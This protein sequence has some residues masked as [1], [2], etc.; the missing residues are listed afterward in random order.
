MAITVELITQDVSIGLQW[1]TLS[2]QESIGQPDTLNIEMVE[3][4]DAIRTLLRPI[5]NY[6]YTAVRKNGALLFSGLATKLLRRNKK[7]AI[8]YT[9]QAVGWEY[10]APKRLV[11]TPYTWSIPPEEEWGDALPTTRH[12]AAS[13]HS[14]PRTGISLRST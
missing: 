5:D 3:I 7:G 8:T 1:R 11:G 10:L 13:R 14:G 4:N 9:L 2:I 6:I 12:L